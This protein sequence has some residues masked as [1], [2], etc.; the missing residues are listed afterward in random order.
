MRQLSLCRR[1]ASGWRSTRSRRT[2]CARPDRARRRH[3]HHVDRRHDLADPRLRPVAARLDQAAR[4][5]TRSTSQK[6]SAPR[7]SP[8]GKSFSELVKRPNLTP[9]G[10]ARDRARVPVESSWWTSGSGAAAR[11]AA[12]ARSS[13]GSERTKQMIVF[14][15]T[16]NLAAP[17]TSRGSSR[18]ILHPAEVQHRR[19]WSCSATGASEV[20]LPRSIDPI[21]KTVR[22]GANEFTVI[23]VLGKR[24]SPAASTSGPTISSSSRT[25]PT[26]SSTASPARRRAVGRQRESSAPR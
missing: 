18:P 6:M 24:P 10:R 7:A 19:R 14:G 8:S 21:G 26:R 12:A 23:G 9:R 11:P 3:R 2:R 22:I 15:A 25:P 17:S 4:A 5:R 16:E 13:T 20:A 1:N